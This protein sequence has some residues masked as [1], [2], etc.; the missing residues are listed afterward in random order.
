[1]P[2]NHRNCRTLTPSIGQTMGHTVKCIIYLESVFNALSAK[3]KIIRLQ[4]A[5]IWADFFINSVLNISNNFVNFSV[6]YPK[7]VIIN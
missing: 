6:I 5:M 7:C 2:K 1:M 3:H 4:L